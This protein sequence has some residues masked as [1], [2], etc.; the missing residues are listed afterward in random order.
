M[1][2]KGLPEN[3][4]RL[5]L[6]KWIDEFRIPHLGTRSPSVHVLCQRLAHE[7]F[8][9]LSQLTIKK[10]QEILGIA[11]QDAAGWHRFPVL[12]G[13]IPYLSIGM[14][15]QDQKYVGQLP[16]VFDTIE[17]SD[18]E[19]PSHSLSLAEEMNPPDEWPSISL[20]NHQPFRVLGHHDLWFFAIAVRVAGDRPHFVYHPQERDLSL[21][22]RAKFS[23]C[24]R[25]LQRALAR[26]QP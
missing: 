26:S 16:V 22:L 6:I 24:K 21:L 10:I 3:D 4:G 15:F 19:S 14:V 23:H 7:D 1:Q 11:S 20:P 17:L 8:E 13:Y 25:L 5:W 2:I 9:S 12:V 18:A